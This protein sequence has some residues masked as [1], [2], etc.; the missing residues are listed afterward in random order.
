MVTNKLHSQMGQIEVS[1]Y[2]NGFVEGFEGTARNII[3]T[4]E[5]KDIVGLLVIGET[6][7]SV[8]QHS[9]YTG[10]NYNYNY[11]NVFTTLSSEPPSKE[12]YI[13]LHVCLYPR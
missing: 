11:Y 6:L 5:R 3:A 1:I 4:A 7:D 13:E 8:G 9:C 10:E 2:N 12:R